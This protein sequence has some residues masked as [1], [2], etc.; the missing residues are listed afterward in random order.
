MTIKAFL[1]TIE[2]GVILKQVA[3]WCRT[4]SAG[5]IILGYLNPALLGNS[6]LINKAIWIVGIPGLG[7]CLVLSWIG[8]KIEALKKGA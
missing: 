6:V 1:T 2:G 7:V 3:D 8:A 4:I 5:A